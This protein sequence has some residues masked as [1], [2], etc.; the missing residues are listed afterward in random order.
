MLPWKTTTLFK[1]TGNS[2]KAQPL[3]GR[4]VH[5][6][7]YHSFLAGQQCTERRVTLVYVTK[8]HEE[9]GLELVLAC[10]H[11]FLGHSLLF[12]QL[13]WFKKWSQKENKEEC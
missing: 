1:E 3:G 8:S 12:E 5:H 9:N 4:W 7:R 13:A 11:R 10:L 6:C 2:G